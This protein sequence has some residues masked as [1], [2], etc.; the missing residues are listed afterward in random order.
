MVVDNGNKSAPSTSMKL[1]NKSV[2]KNLQNMKTSSSLRRI[3]AGSA[4]ALLA[5]LSAQAVTYYWDGND[6]TAGF[7]T[8]TG[9]WAAPTIGTTTSGWSTGTGVGAVPVAASAS[10]AT[11][12]AG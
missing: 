3:L 10:P 12:R 8:A 9:T 1:T 6:L 4:A 2:H 11:G 7:G 5:T